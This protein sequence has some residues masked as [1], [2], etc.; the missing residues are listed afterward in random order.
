MYFGLSRVAARKCSS[1]RTSSLRT[2]SITAPRPQWASALFG[3]SSTQRLN[4]SCAA[5]QG[6]PP[7]FAISPPPIAHHA[8]LISGSI[9]TAAR[10]AAR[11]SS[12]LPCLKNAMPSSKR[13]CAV[14]RAVGV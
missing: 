12:T 10:Y 1:A 14:A 13:A 3:L 4:G 2:R 6:C 5:S 8:S 7:F 11:A 9:S